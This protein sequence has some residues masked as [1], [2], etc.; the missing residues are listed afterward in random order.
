MSFIT[1]F[2]KSDINMH[3]LRVSPQTPPRKPSGCACGLR[4]FGRLGRLC[5]SSVQGPG[6]DEVLP[7]PHE[8]WRLGVDAELR[9][10]RAQQSVVTAALHR[11]R[12][13]RAQVTRCH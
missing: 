8:R 11:Q 2:S 7:V 4:R 5:C 10:Y 12:E 9:D 13:L 6:D 1:Q 3:S